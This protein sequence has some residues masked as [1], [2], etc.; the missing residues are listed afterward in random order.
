MNRF[1]LV[2][3]QFNYIIFRIMFTH[4]ISIAITCILFMKFF[5]K[6]NWLHIIL[7]TLSIIVFFII[8]DQFHLTRWLDFIIR[9]IGAIL[10]LIITFIFTNGVIVGNRMLN[11]AQQFRINKWVSGI[12][13]QNRNT[14]MEMVL[15]RTLVGT[16]D[17]LEDVS[18]RIYDESQKVPT[19]AR[20]MYLAALG[21]IYAYIGKDYNQ[22]AFFCS[23]CLKE[24]DCYNKSYIIAEPYKWM[25]ND[26]ELS[27]YLFDAEGNTI[28]V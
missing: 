6:S 23:K 4:I 15:E 25:A 20:P 27:K 9:G 3:L 28:F 13:S 10:I 11:T 14:Y 16:E 5:L 22:S 7:C 24:L 19:D 26:P 18:S 2:Y 12:P 8:L 21:Y 1:N 17:S